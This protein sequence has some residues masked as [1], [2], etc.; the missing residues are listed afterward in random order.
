M[1]V[2]EAVAARRSVRQFMDDPVDLNLLRSVLDKSLRSPSGGNVQPWNAHVVSGAPLARLFEAVAP[3]L[4]GAS[5]HN[6]E[7]D[8]YPPTLAGRYRDSRFGV[9]N[10]M[11]EALGIEREDKLRRRAQM[12]RNYRAFGAP[13]VMFVHTP[14]YMGPPQWSDIGMWLQTV[15]LLLQEAGLDSC[16]QEAWSV[17]HRTIREI[18]PVPDDHILYC[19]MAIGR[20]DPEAAINNFAVP[21]SSLTEVVAFHCG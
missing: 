14:R 15:M 13:V 10:K 16:C 9:A 2:S 18:I 12:N 8:I 21:R 7:F 20:R 11:Y 19:G 5:D 1:N 4:E 3:H 6:P 17:Y